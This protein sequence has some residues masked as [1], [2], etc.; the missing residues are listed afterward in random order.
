MLCHVT[1]S[2]ALP[3]ITQAPQPTGM[4]L[5]PLKVE[6]I[7]ARVISGN[8]SVASAEGGEGHGDKVIMGFAE[9]SSEMTAQLSGKITVTSTAGLL[10]QA[11]HAA[12]LFYT[13]A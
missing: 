5:H 6:S 11:L 4:E 1:W 10:S 7:K 8:P 12:G 9:D 3:S 13:R 2:T